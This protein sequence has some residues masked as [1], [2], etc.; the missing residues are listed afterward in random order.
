MDTFAVGVSGR[1]RA[2]EGIVPFVFLACPVCTAP[3][4]EYELVQHTRGCMKIEAGECRDWP[5]APLGATAAN[6]FPAS[7]SPGAQGGW[8]NFPRRDS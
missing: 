3:L 8:G 4:R 7:P 1:T 6:P 2:V 5:V